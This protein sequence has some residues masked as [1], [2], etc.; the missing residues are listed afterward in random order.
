MLR[1]NQ[2]FEDPSNPALPFRWALALLAALIPLPFAFAAMVFVGEALFRLCPRE[3][4]E[5]YR[6]TATWF[7]PVSTALAA[8]IILATAYFVVALPTR[9]APS[10]KSLVARSVAVVGI[11]FYLMLLASGIAAATWPF[12]VWCIG[13]ASTAYLVCRRNAHAA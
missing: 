9:L 3:Q 8:L 11:A 7:A 4:M 6:C 2:P 12:A 1:S 10:S 13:C 5:Q